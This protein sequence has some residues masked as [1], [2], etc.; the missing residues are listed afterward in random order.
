MD[1]PNRLAVTMAAMLLLPCWGLAGA[2]SVWLAARR[3]LGELEA[4][5]CMFESSGRGGASEPYSGVELRLPAGG[6]WSPATESADTMIEGLLDPGVDPTDARATP[7]AEPGAPEA[8]SEDREA[9]GSH[10][11]TVAVTGAA[12][13]V[14]LPELVLTVLDWNL[15]LRSARVRL[16]KTRTQIMRE[17]AV[18]D[19]TVGLS[20]QRQHGWQA[21]T[22]LLGLG[23]ERH[24]VESEQVAAGVS[25]QLAT[26]TRYSLSAEG[27]RALDRAGVG[28]G[29]SPGEG[30]RTLKVTQPLLRG[31]GRMIACGKL[32]MAQLGLETS[33]HQLERL[34]ESTIGEVEAAY[35]ELHGTE[36]T[37]RI[38]G[39]S[40]AMASKLL[41]RNQELFKRGLATR[42]DVIT[43]EQ[44]L[45]QRD[46][47]C[48]TAAQ[49][50]A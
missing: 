34:I 11:P 37:V 23:F 35:W 20:A 5:R 14:P 25:G 10:R 29:T 40:R 28:V 17:R 33:S 50:R 30:T 8:A 4:R 13:P 19:P 15:A 7:A 42:V 49:R 47:V 31:R 45:A 21:W 16:E 6:R 12:R 9:K 38:A 39:R 24:G 22:D 43:A 32:R 44:G 18:F 36:A 27:A 26:S 3:D 2:D 48:I 41:Y 46:A 1:R